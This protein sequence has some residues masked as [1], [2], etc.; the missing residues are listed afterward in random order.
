MYVSGIAWPSATPL[1]MTPGSGGSGFFEGFVF[2]LEDK[3]TK[4]NIVKSQQAVE[5][6]L[7][8]YFDFIIIP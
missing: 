2:A 3:H 8:N 4:M 7:T 6:L 1:A 5:K